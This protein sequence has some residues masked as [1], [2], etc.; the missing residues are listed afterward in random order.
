MRVV[1]PPT[2]TVTSA[3][4]VVTAGGMTFTV[5]SVGSLVTK[6]TLFIEHTTRLSGTYVS[7]AP[8]GVYMGVSVMFDSTF[9]IPGDPETITTKHSAWTPPN[10]ELL[11][12]DPSPDRL[13]DTAAMEGYRGFKQK[14]LGKFFAKS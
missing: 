5:T 11:K 2:T 4:G 12:T 9:S 7:T 3:G 6:P 14:L 13:Y 10:T 8:R 1:L